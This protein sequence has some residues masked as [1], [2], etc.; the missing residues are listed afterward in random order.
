MPQGKWHSK[1]TIDCNVNPFSV[2][3]VLACQDNT[4]KVVHNVKPGSRALWQVSLRDA[5]GNNQYFNRPLDNIADHVP[6]ILERR[7]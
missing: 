1:V 5:K 2:C 3:S 6:L 4:D 7:E